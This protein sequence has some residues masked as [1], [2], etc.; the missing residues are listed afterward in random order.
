MQS[1]PRAANKAI[2]MQGSCRMLHINMQHWPHNQN[3][4]QNKP[5]QSLGRNFKFP[6]QLPR[7]LHTVDCGC[8]EQWEMTKLESGE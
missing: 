8:N 6:Q 7:R 5:K 2:A 4:D 3:H 1:K